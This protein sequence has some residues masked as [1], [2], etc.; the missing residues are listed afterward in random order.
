MTSS[1][2][3]SRAGR[4]SSLGA[5]GE[6][7]VHGDRVEDVALGAD[8]GEGAHGAQRPAAGAGLDEVADRGAERGRGVAVEVVG[9]A[10][11]HRP[12]GLGPEGAAPAAG[13]VGPVELVV[14]EQH[15][16]QRGL[17]GVRLRGEPPVARGAGVDGS[18]GHSPVPKWR[19]TS[20]AET[21]PSSWKP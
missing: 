17:Q 12:P 13:A 18:R 10:V 3:T 4:S 8:L 11:V 1:T 6:A 21:T 15:E 5:G 19:H 9:A 14:V 20:R 2:T 16:V 7:V